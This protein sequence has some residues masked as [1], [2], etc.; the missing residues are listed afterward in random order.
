M[1]AASKE[2]RSNNSTTS[3]KYKT[4]EGQEQEQQTSKA[5]F[6]AS[7]KELILEEEVRAVTE[8]T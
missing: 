1:A 6:D 7:E 4:K 5:M 3:N 2:G 8:L